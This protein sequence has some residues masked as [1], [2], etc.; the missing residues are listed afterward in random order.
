VIALDT[1]VLIRFLVR[2]DEP[3][4]LRAR[5]LLEAC[6]ER[7]EAC[8]VTNPV[9][10]EVEWVLDSVYKA[11]RANVGAALRTLQTTPPFALE[12]E[13]LLE[14]ALRNY[15]RGKGD[16]SDYLLGEIGEARG[17]RTTF[18]FDRK[19]RGAGRFSLL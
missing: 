14:R 4:A 19:L 12:D 1:N 7:G 9:L 15:V 10:C 16:F 13:A 11:S 17:A 6:R 5:A 2:D 8:L 18:T 3:Q